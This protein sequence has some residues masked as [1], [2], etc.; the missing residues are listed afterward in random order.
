MKW[1]MGNGYG[2]EEIHSGASWTINMSEPGNV[3]ANEV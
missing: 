1:G 2:E 3:E